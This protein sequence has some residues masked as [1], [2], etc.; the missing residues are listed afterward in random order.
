[1]SI[2]SSA[3]PCLKNM[4]LM[5]RRS[6]PSHIGRGRREIPIGS[7]FISLQNVLEF[8]IS[9]SSFGGEKIAEFHEVK[10]IFLQI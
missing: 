4:V 8:A 6:D 1:V 9:L 10:C 2:T 5:R 3:T 7:E